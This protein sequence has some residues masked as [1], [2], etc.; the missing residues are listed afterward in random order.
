M[1]DRMW[2]VDLGIPWGSFPG[3]GHR[4]VRSGPGPRLLPLLWGLGVVGTYLKGRP[5]GL[6]WLRGWAPGFLSPHQEELRAFLSL[7]FGFPP[8]WKI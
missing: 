2:G 4:W 8:S 5:V 1:K 3:G 6:G 7:M